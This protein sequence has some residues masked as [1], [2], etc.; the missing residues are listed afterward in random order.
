M[1]RQL[2]ALALLVACA[3]PEG[4]TRL[5]FEDK[6]ALSRELTADVEAGLYLLEVPAGSTVVVDAFAAEGVAMDAGVEGSSERCAVRGD[7]FASCTFEAEAGATVSVFVD[8]AA[9]MS[10]QV[11][12]HE[13]VDYD[14]LGIEDDAEYD[15]AA[16]LSEVALADA[17]A[18]DLGARSHEGCQWWGHGAAVA[19]AATVTMG[20]STAACA[21]AG[22]VAVLAT[23][24][25][26]AVVAAPVCVTLAVGTGAAAATEV[27]MRGGQLVCENWSWILQSVE[28][29]ADDLIAV[30]Y[31]GLRYILNCNFGAYLHQQAMKKLFC[32]W[33][34]NGCRGD[35]SCGD[36]RWRAANANACLAARNWIQ[37]C[38]GDQ[39]DR[40]HRCEHV[41]SINRANRCNARVAY[42]GTGADWQ[43]APIPAPGTWVQL[44]T[45]PE[46]R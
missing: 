43:P 37:S 16:L 13:E 29:L 18:E 2:V 17:R 31:E 21:A 20:L 46:C 9:E 45:P 23:A 34:A 7:A 41:S 40:N 3:T 44:P 30:T 42:C 39:A 36:V 35:L 32:H 33:R 27:L 14:V 4:A 6:S 26:A 10:V 1:V 11:L 8:A 5:H 24:G 19:R 22:G 28:R 38:W 15:P 12:A 25:G